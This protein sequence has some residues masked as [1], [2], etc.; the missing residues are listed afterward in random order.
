MVKYVNIYNKKKQYGNRCLLKLLTNTNNI[1]YIRITTRPNH[2]Y[3]FYSN[4]KLI[5]N[6]IK[7]RKR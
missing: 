3:S 1:K 2:Q 6:R 7:K 5:L 4:K